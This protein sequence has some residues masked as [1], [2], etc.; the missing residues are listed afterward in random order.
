MSIRRKELPLPPARKQERS[1][2]LE[3]ELP[4][5]P[6][7]ERPGLKRKVDEGPERGEMVID[8]FGSEDTFCI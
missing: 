3:L 6:P 7:E 5:P 1:R 8:M 2:E 4:V